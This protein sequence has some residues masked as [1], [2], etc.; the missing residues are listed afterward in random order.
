V[1]AGQKVGW[2]GAAPGGEGCAQKQP[3]LVCPVAIRAC[4][5]SI[6]TSVEHLSP[7]LRD[8]LREAFP[9]RVVIEGD[10]AAWRELWQDRSKS[11]SILPSTQDKHQ[12]EFAMPYERGESTKQDASQM[13]NS[14]GT[15]ESAE[16]NARGSGS[17]APAHDEG[18]SERL[19][20]I[21]SEER[22]LGEWAEREGLLVT[23]LP[24][25]DELHGEHGIHYNPKSKRY[26]KFTRHDRHQGYGI[27][28]GSHLHG[29]SPAEYLDRIRLQNDVFSDDIKLDGILK[30]S[31]GRLSIITSQPRIVGD[32]PTLKEIDALMV[33]KGFKKLADGAFVDQSRG[34]L[35]YDLFPR[36]AVK[37][38]DG[39]VYPIDPVIQRVSPD[40]VDFLAKNPERIHD[41]P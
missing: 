6:Q 41:R 20:R 11:S 12:S 2:V 33:G 34:I 10:D 40:F 7:E 23:E 13:A 17:P 1:A 32:A 37:S 22:R 3:D 8:S 30:R 31:G 9:E 16:S 27:A 21:R 14:Q 28:L 18:R 39:T 25:A 36:N 38:A 4:C 5:S 19:E 24:P 35:V 15:L 29:A 26:F